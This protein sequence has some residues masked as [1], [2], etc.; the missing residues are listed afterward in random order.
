VD[1]SVTDPEAKKKVQEKADEINARTNGWLYK[2]SPGE[3]ET[4]TTKMKDI[5]AKPKES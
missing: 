3:G 4:L 5:L 2:L 1:V